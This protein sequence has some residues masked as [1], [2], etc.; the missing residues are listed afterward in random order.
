MLFGMESK[1]VDMNWFNGTEVE[2]RQWA[3]LQPPVPI[4]EPTLEEKVAKLWAAHP[5]LH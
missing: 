5:E 4:P 1:Q 2:L 3:G